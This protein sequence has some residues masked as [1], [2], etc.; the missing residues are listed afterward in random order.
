MPPLPAFICCS[1]VPSSMLKMAPHFGHLIF[2]SFEA[3][4]HPIEKTVNSINA[5]K[6]LIHFVMVIYLLSS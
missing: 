2:V 6:I 4:V 3:P 5:K 1:T